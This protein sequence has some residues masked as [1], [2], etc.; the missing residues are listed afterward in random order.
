MSKDIRD[1]L[2]YNNINAKFNLTLNEPGNKDKFSGF[3]KNWQSNKQDLTSPN[4]N[5]IGINTGK[6]NGITVLDLDSAKEHLD[7]KCGIELFERNVCNLNEIKTLTTKTPNNGYHIYYKYTNKLKTGAKLKIGN[8]T[9]SIDIRNDKACATEGRNYSLFVDANDL[10]EVPDSLIQLFCRDDKIKEYESKHKNEDI[11][12]KGIS[13]ILDNLDPLYYNTYTNWFNVICVLKNLDI[14][15]KTVVDFSKKSVHFKEEEYVENIYDKI[16]K[17]DTPGIGSL[18]FYLKESVSDYKYKQIVK[19]IVNIKDKESQR[20]GDQL[21]YELFQKFYENK[22]ITDEDLNIYLINNF[23]IWRTVKKTNKSIQTMI[24]DFSNHLEMEN[25]DYYLGDKKYRDSFL[26]GLITYLQVEDLKFNTDEY[27]LPFRNGVLELK[28]GDFRNAKPDEYIITYINY[29]YIKT[30]TKQIDHFFNQLFDSEEIKMFFINCLAFCLENLNRNQIIIF[31]IGVLARN[32]KSTVLELMKLALDIFGIRISTN[33]L[34]GKR[35]EAN[36]TNEALMALKDRR[37]AYCTEPESGKKININVVKELTGDEISVRANYGKQENFKV[38]ATIFLS[39]QYPPELDDI[40]AGIV[41]RIRIIPF[42]NQFVEN[43]VKQNERQLKS[44]TFEEKEILKLE[45][46][47]LLINTYTNLYNNGFNY[48][49]PDIVKSNTQDYFN[50]NNELDNFI[51][52]TFEFKEG[53]FIKIDIVK[54]LMKS[55]SIKTSITILK[56]RLKTLLKVDFYK[57]KMIK[58]IRYCS[59][60]YNLSLKEE[61][62]SENVNDDLS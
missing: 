16:E 11:N 12:Q 28:T 42:N 19:E 40:D 17:R 43:P 5:N 32:G 10:E 52:D 39:S 57:D 29:D 21:A 56:S 15:L 26:S 33:L 2:Y 60:F 6:I 4:T 1:S 58:N 36:N 23:G 48:T 34:T 30:D 49:T 31:M 61:T 35:E 54:N 27:L 44:F 62:E 13:L 51:N 9:Y 59:I 50:D 46:M 53:S 8:F 20:I 24:F 3:F 18:Y 41:R 55:K 14:P 47:N 37:F 25:Y 45:L 7:E 38:N 22:I